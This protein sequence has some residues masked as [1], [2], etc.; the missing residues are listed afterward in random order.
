LIDSVKGC[1]DILREVSTV[2]GLS[3]EDR[4]ALTESI[5]QKMGELKAVK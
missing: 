2:E 5:N 4:D 3:E 1:L